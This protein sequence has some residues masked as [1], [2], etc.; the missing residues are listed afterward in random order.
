MYHHLMKLSRPEPQYRNDM[1]I[2]VSHLEQFES[3]LVEYLSELNYLRNCQHLT[4]KQDLI[5]T[6]YGESA[7][8]RYEELSHT[9]YQGLMSRSNYSIP[10]K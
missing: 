2:T 3:W 4:P 1:K 7:K 8:L 10:P 6:Q 5:L 9:Y